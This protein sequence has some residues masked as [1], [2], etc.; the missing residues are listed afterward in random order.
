M[1]VSGSMYRFNGYDGRLNKMLETTC[2]IMEALAAEELRGRYEY[3]ILGHSG[4]T[5]GEELGLGLG[6][7]LGLVVNPNLYP[8]T[9]TLTLTRRGVRRLCLPPPRPRRSAQGA[10]ADGD[11]QPV[12]HGRRQHH[13]G[14]SP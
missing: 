10:A 9:L 12:L 6:L 14:D 5:D 13:R 1:D 3:A 2:L 11:P 7:G 4:E 8:L